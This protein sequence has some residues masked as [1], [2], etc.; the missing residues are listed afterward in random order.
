M[1]DIVSIHLFKP[2]EY[3]TPS[4]NPMVNSG[5]RVIM[6]SQC[7][8]FRCTKRTTVVGGVYNRRGY[9]CVSRKYM[10][11]L[12]IFLNFAVNLITTALKKIKVLNS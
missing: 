9:A 3:T 1:V 4:V 7:R 12:H 11:N 10:G 6:M 2:M 5:P 8:F